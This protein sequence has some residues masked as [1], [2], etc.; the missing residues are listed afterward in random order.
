VKVRS[1]NKQHFDSAT[2]S[3]RE[4]MKTF[5]NQIE[6]L[7]DEL[8]YRFEER[9]KEGLA[10]IGQQVE[11]LSDFGSNPSAIYDKVLHRHIKNVYKKREM[12]SSYASTNNE[13]KR[14]AKDNQ[15]AT[16]EPLTA[17]EN[18]VYSMV[19]DN[20]SV[21]DVVD[22]FREAP[23][24]WSDTEI[25]HVLLKL[26]TKSKIRFKEH[27]EETNRIDFAA[28][29]LRKPDRPALT[30]HKAESYEPSY[31]QKVVKAINSKIFNQQLIN[32]TQDHRV[33]RRDII[34]E[35]EKK[36]EELEERSSEWAG[37]PFQKHF[38]AF[39]DVLRTLKNTREE[40]KFFDTIIENAEEW[41][42]LNDTC[43]ELEDFLNTNGD[44]YKKIRNFVEDN[45]TNF[46]DL[47][48]ADKADAD[49]LV[50]F[51][52]SDAPHR[53]FVSAR[54]AYKAVGKSLDDE[55]EE[56]RKETKQKYEQ[57]IET[58]K[59]QKVEEEAEEYQVPDLDRIQA[60]VEGIRSISQLKNKK[61][62][63]EIFRNRE[64]E[65]LYE[66]L[67]RKPVEV[68]VKRGV[69]IKSEEDLNSYV[70]N[71]KG[72]IE[73]ALKDGSTVIIK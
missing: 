2:G 20:L 64:L 24:G 25:V 16:D 58:L 67:E 50:R 19:T 9:F 39:T 37:Y 46:D 1:Y 47:E 35:L 71:L 23:Y 40:K 69:T 49:K 45:R 26:D 14:E 72:D 27:N 34:G 44:R 12:A 15:T 57:T 70:E 4:A 11:P 32:T 21:A 28:K 10:I 22:Q 60:E 13:V 8:R 56:Q 54:K 18:E 36:H 33:L 6:K 62:E 42:A 48:P 68:P 43:L 61:Y 51:L 52:Q 3:K 55:L 59:A 5:S 73:K 29:A 65:K 66:S 7:L 30:L 31:L 53:E 38:K 17:A 41:G 63:S